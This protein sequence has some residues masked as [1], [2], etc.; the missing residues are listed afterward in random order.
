MKKTLAESI[1]DVMDVVQ[2][3]SGNMEFALLDLYNEGGGNPTAELAAEIADDYTGVTAEKLLAAYPDWAKQHEAK[4][5]EPPAMDPEKAA[6]KKA[7][8]QKQGIKKYHADLEAKREKHRQD[9]AAFN[10]K[11]ADLIAE[12]RKKAEDAPV[13]E[14]WAKSFDDNSE[15]SGR[16]GFVAEM[17]YTNDVG[18]IK[19]KVSIEIS[20]PESKF[21]DKLDAYMGWGDTLFSYEGKWFTF[22]AYDKHGAAFHV[23]DKYDKPLEAM[24]EIVAEQEAKALAAIARKEERG[25]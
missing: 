20:D 18:N 8:D 13:P 3:A 6:Q 16:R 22:S 21:A 12:V 11:H 23:S 2:E 15:W 24:D 17:T 5:N 1:R 7:W 25:N 14:G 4:T 19:L 10:E 9:V